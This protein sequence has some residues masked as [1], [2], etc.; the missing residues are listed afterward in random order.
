V[1]VT[2]VLIG[3]RDSRAHVALRGQ[4]SWPE[5][6][7]DDGPVLE[8]A[9]VL[10]ELDDVQKPTVLGLIGVPDKQFGSPGS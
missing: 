4:A 10:A 2:A 9:P 3:S 8:P 7:T 6:V 5:L 1:G